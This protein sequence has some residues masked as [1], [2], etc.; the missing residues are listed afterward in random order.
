MHILLG[1]SLLINLV[2]VIYWYLTKQHLRHTIQHLK[3]IIAGSSRTSLKLS[4]HS[5]VQ[6][7]VVIEINQL[8]E[9]LNEKTIN[10][11]Q[12]MQEN[13]RMVTSISHDFRTPLTSMLGYIQMLK[14]EVYTANEEKYVTIIEERTRTLNH[15]VEE[16]YTLSILDSNEYK[17][18]IQQVNP[19]LL[20]QE[21]LATYYDE[22]EKSFDSIEV[23]IAE[24]ALFIQ[25]SLNDFKRIIGNILKNAFQ[26][27]TGTFQAETVLDNNKLSFIFKNEVD[28]P[29][30]I[31]VDRLFERLYRVDES[32]QSSSSG[33]G[34]SIAKKLAEQLRMHLDAEL[35]GKTLA[36]TLTI[37]VDL[38]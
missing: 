26:Y 36:F 14:K 31:K 6:D 21:Q 8:I 10:F 33:L 20:V 30:K 9:L 2:F 19:I 37:P 23:S 11:E 7:K 3:R 1:L 25:T 35:K 4:S 17:P 32:R 18:P 27:G 22:L 38:L 5:R 12:V 28:H 34:L 16:F 13:K 29:E 24:E 15:L